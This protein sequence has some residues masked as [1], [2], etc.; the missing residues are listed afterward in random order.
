MPQPPN[1]VT[2]VMLWHLAADVTRNHRPD[3]DG[4]CAHP[5]CKGAPSPCPPLQLA[6]RADRTARRPTIATSR[7][8]IAA[9][10]SAAPTAGYPRRTPSW[11]ALLGGRGTRPTGTP[12]RPPCWHSFSPDPPPSKPS[13][14]ASG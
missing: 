6:R 12:T 5:I 14:T 4:R 7:V 3:T 10:P 13:L 9:I 11:V 8:T 2:D 1:D